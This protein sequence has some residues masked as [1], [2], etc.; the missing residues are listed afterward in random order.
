MT[1]HGTIRRFTTRTQTVLLSCTVFLS[2]TALA[3]CGS[4]RLN[5]RWLDRPINIDGF[6]DDWEGALFSVNKGA[7][8]VG[9]MNDSNNVYLCVMT[10]KAQ[11]QRRLLRAGLVVWF[12]PEDQDKAML[13]IHY[14]VGMLGSDRSPRFAETDPV[15]PDGRPPD[16]LISDDRSPDDRALTQE[17]SVVEVIG[18][19]KQSRKRVPLDSIPGVEVKVSGE[20]AW[21]VYELRIPLAPPDR[22][23]LAIDAKPGQMIT[24]HLESEKPNMR[25]ARG[26]GPEGG[27]GGRSGGGFGGGGMG[28]GGR[29]G[30][31]GGPGPG[32]Q[33]GS[34]Q[35]PEQFNVSTKVKLAAAPPI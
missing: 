32:G 3:G 6:A 29:G 26:G 28:R 7:A 24:I 5:S 2:L 12:Q 4:M 30:G 15:S 14:P 17:L 19:D 27:Q 25:M 8:W 33:G 34:R 23:P 20:K 16:G 1:D 11:L 22:F 18:P 31:M 9:V 13:G 10:A 35:A 21:F